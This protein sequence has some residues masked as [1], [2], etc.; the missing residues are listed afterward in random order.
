MNSSK[1]IFFFEQVDG[2]SVGKDEEDKE[3]GGGDEKSE[4]QK[5]KV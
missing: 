1:L 3:D 4:T 2:E 5:S